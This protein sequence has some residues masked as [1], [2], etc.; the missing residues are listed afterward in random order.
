M[1]KLLNK[2]ESLNG[3][4][5]LKNITI[6]N[7]KNY[8]Q[9]EL[10]FCNKINSFTGDNGV[11]KTNLL[12]AIYYLS[13]CKSY[14]NSIDGQNIRRGEKFFT[15]QGSYQ[16]EERKEIVFCGL[17]KGQKKVF[18]RNNKE[19]SKL[20][21]HIGFLPLVMI[22]PNDSSLILEGSEERRKFIDTVI[23][24]YDKDYLEQLIKYNR[25]L[26]QRNKLLKHF[27][28]SKTFDE[29]SLEIWDEQLTFASKKI[30]E[31]RVN[32]IE[33]MK[34]VFQ[35]FYDFI[36][37]GKE[38]VELIYRSQLHEDNHLNLLKETQ[39]KDKILQYT[40]TGIHRD[41]LVLNLEQYSIKKTG[42]QGQQK[43]FLVALKLAQ[44]EFISRYNNF[45][46]ILLLDDIFDKFD[47]KRVQKIIQLVS[48]NRFGQIFISDTSKERLSQFLEQT[49]IEHKHFI[50]YENKISEQF[51]EK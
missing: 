12:D 36:S 44:F 45:S 1:C 46:P 27:A 18:K 50:I 26:S 6:F 11:G 31:T 14:F 19:Y 47:K 42:S 4:M 2:N 43:T 21:E 8:E 7:Y 32:F 40:S 35:E 13:F 30:Y 9:V 34:P 23:S 29:I 33:K 17:K 15:I 22:S 38:S 48:E 3:T 28:T 16:R 41:D 10:E 39:E 37:E 51:S 5:C 25:A 49:D 24:Q 20:S